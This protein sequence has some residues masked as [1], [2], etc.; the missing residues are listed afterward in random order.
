[1]ECEGAFIRRFIASN[2]VSSANYS[3]SVSTLLDSRAVVNSN[4]VYI[5]R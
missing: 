3:G 5:D 2:F 4:L 1:M